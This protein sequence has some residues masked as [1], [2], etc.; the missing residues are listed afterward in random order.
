MIGAART[1]M[2]ISLCLVGV[3]PSIVLVSNW[4]VRRRGLALGILLTGT[5]IGGVV[6]PQIATPLITAYGWRAAMLAAESV[7]TSTAHV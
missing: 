7:N 6:I 2:G 5:S 1:M 4:F 3:L